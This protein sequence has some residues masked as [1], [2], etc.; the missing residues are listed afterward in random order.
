MASDIGDAGSGGTGGGGIG[1]D[2]DGPN[3]M[4]RRPPDRGFEEVSLK[5]TLEIDSA[6]IFD[7]GVE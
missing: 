3:D 6:F 1:G 2:F 5:G 4:E 7:G